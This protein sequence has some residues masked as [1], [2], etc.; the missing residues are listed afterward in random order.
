MNWSANNVKNTLIRIAFWVIFVGAFGL[1]GQGDYEYR[2]LQAHKANPAETC[3]L[4][5]K[6]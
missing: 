1:T 2:C 6:P 4:G 3:P 5:A